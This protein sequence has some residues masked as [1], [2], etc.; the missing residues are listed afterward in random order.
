MCLKNSKGSRM[1][2]EKRER[3]RQDRGGQLHMLCTARL[4]KAQLTCTTVRHAEPSL[5]KSSPGPGV[6][7]EV[8]EVL[9]SPMGQE[10]AF[11]L[12]EIGS[13]CQEGSEPEA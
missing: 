4:K 6:G 10:K 8:R 2:G 13:R 5:L 1:A 3:G 11:P 7:D 9:G 12:S